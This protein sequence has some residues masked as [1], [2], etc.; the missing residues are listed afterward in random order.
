MI[1]SLATDCWI[2][3]ETE[4]TDKFHY[5]W[6]QPLWK[7]ILV[8]RREHE[9]TD[10]SNLIPSLNEID[11]AI[12]DKKIEMKELKKDIKLLK[13]FL[14]NSDKVERLNDLDN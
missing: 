11:L 14:A 1:L 12:Y 13:D 2:K 9:K 10:A 6:S 5:Q 3:Q 8:I 7:H 4:H